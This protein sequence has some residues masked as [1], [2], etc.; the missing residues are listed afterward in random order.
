MTF[1]ID[2]DVKI[3]LYGSTSFIIGESKLGGPALLGDLSPTWHPLTCGVVSVDI[4]R[5][6]SVNQSILPTLEVGTASIVL[7]GFAVDPTLNPLF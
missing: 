4:D 7:S 2:E 1:R 3:E 5:G 6:F